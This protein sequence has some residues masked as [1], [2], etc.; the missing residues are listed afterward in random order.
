MNYKILKNPNN[1]EFQ[2]ISE[3]VE[4]NEGYCPCA[5]Q[6]NDGTKCVCKEFRETNSA[7]FCHCGRYY[8]ILDTIKIAL[9]ADITESIEELN[10]WYGILERQGFVVTPVVFDERNPF[11][12]S[13]L[14]EDLS[15]TK[16]SQ[17][18][19]VVLLDDETDWLLDKE[20]WAEGMMKKIIRRSEID[21]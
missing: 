6:Q 13:E 8:K 16:I 17:A 9:V 7:D 10:K 4:K 11:H 14:Y 3:V 5:I 18:D 1:E 15:R 12:F 21:T 19:A 20:A 2:E